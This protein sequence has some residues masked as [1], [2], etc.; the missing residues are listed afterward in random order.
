[1]RVA[2]TLFLTL[3]AWSAGYDADPMHVAP[4]SPIRSRLLVPTHAAHGSEVTA[5]NG[6]P[7]LA[8]TRTPGGYKTEMVNLRI[9]A[10]P[11]PSADGANDRTGKRVGLQQSANPVFLLIGYAHLRNRS[12]PTS[13]DGNFKLVPHLPVSFHF[14]GRTVELQLQPN[15]KVDQA[16]GDERVELFQVNVKRGAAWIPLP[17]VATENYNAVELM[18]AGDLDGDGKV[19]FLF[20]DRGYNWSSLRLFLSTAAKFGQ[21]VG[22]VA[23]FYQTGC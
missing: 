3:T 11:D 14:A 10:V 23:Q 5:R 6:E 21:V 4:T 19:D 22:E 16:P 20:E 18:W 17:I 7:W 1:M 8:L 15:G 13:F 9:T 2:A 12:I